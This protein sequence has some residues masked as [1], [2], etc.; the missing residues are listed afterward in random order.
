MGTVTSAGGG[1]SGMAN[2]SAGEEFQGEGVLWTN[3]KLITIGHNYIVLF[4]K[5]LSCILLLL[6]KSKEENTLNWL[7][8][9]LRDNGGS[10]SVTVCCCQTTE[11]ILIW[12][13]PRT[14]PKVKVLGSLF[15]K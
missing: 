10:V 2:F 3:K 15:G 11:A 8:I 6:I 9:G 7:S 14:D 5:E 1:G 12:I 4:D 13:P